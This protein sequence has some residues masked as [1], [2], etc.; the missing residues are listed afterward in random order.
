MFKGFKDDKWL[1]LKISAM[2][3][4]LTISCVL[5]SNFGR[6]VGGSSGI[7]HSSDN[8]LGVGLCAI[9]LLSPIVLPEY[10]KISWTKLGIP[11]LVFTII[12]CSILALIMEGN[13]VYYRDLLRKEHYTWSE[14]PPIRW[15]FWNILF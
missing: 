13:E 5:I 6:I 10:R 14:C 1:P 12:V 3:F 15:D 2:S 9:L 7:R 8:W 11:T 4:V